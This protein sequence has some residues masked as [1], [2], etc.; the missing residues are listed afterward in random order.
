MT[1]HIQ[2]LRSAAEPAPQPP[3][4]NAVG[5]VVYRYTRRGQL[6][7]LLIRKRGGYW[8]LP[9]GQLKDDEA[10]AEG[11]VREVHEETGINGSVETLVSAVRY[12]V[13]KRGIPR[14]KIV[15]YYL[16]R[17]IS[18]QLQP[19]KKE[20]IER[21]KWFA[22]P[23]ALRRIKRG[24]VRMVAMHASVLLSDVAEGAADEAP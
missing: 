19:D 2:P 4:I 12:T 21:V 16:I 13:Y 22:A 20:Q 15:S 10:D 18:G 8:T 11:V 23:A 17:A 3:A 7:F 1:A 5:G 24:R 6:Q 14:C 9:K